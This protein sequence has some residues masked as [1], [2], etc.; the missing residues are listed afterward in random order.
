MYRDDIETIVQVFTEVAKADFFFKITV[1]GG[2]DAHIHLFGAASSDP[3][4]F[5][6]LQDPEDFHLKADIHFPYFI[7]KHR[8]ALSQL[9]TSGLAADGM[10]KR[11]LFMTK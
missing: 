1:C 4:Y 10:R 8:A 7:K 6:F 5:L 11:S 3:L 9:K 2:Y